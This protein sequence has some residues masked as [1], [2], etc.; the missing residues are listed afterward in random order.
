MEVFVGL[1]VIWIVVSVIRAVWTNASDVREANQLREH[2]RGVVEKGLTV[3]CSNGSF[4]PSVGGPSLAVARV[5]ISGAIVVPHDNQPVQFRV[6]VADISEDSD[7][8]HPIFCTIPELSDEDGIYVSDQVSEI[9]YQ[10]SE[11][12]E[13]PIA[14]IPLFALVGP[15]GGKRKIRISVA[16]T[17]NDEW[18]PVFSIG[19]TEFTYTAEGV[20]YL[21][22]KERTEALEQQI[23]ALALAMAAADGHIDKRELNVIRR[24]FSERF[25]GMETADNR[26]QKVTSTLQA[27]LRQIRSDNEKPGRII[28]RLCNE[29]HTDGDPSVAQSAYELCVEIAG[30]DQTVGRREQKALDYIAERLELPDEFVREAHDRRLRLT[31]YGETR[32]QDL[33]D[34]PQGLSDDEKR[35]F[36]NSEYRKWRARATHKDKQIAAEASLRLERITKLR[37]Q[38]SEA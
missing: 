4:E 3:H 33:I 25:A 11:V 1:I 17:P 28:A 37:A 18:E 32:E 14:G 38:L 9:P 20:G 24:Y 7:D 8:P 16:V 29:L 30:A 31:M 2:V 22:L 27:T 12:S 5:S 13:M 15:R 35:A 10:L 6:R 34:M 26:R 21:E 36:L 19:S 23:A